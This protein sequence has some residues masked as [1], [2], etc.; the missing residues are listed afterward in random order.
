MG[1]YYFVTGIISLVIFVFLFAISFLAFA[2]SHTSEGGL[3]DMIEKVL[4]LV[5]GCFAAIIVPTACFMSGWGIYGL[6]LLIQAERKCGP[7]LYDLVIYAL[8]AS[9]CW[10]FFMKCL[11]GQFAGQK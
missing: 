5:V 11:V 7:K 2:R 4:M 8:I 6:V 10:N 9:L 3:H 1:T